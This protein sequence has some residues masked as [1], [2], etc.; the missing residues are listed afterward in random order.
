MPL[1]SPQDKGAL[2]V[3]VDPRFLHPVMGAIRAGSVPVLKQLLKAN[4]GFNIQKFVDD[5]KKIENSRKPEWRA[6]CL[7]GDSMVRQNWDMAA[8]LIDHDLPLIG[9]DIQHYPRQTALPL[10]SQL[11]AWTG[12]ANDIRREV[13]S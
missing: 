6:L 5:A 13:F 10:A 9:R 2:T 8:F 7:V 1:T 3:D 12:I 4:P 11:W